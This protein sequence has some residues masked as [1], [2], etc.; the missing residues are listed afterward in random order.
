MQQHFNEVQKLFNFGEKPK[1]APQT[2]QPNSV[3]QIH[4]QSTNVEEQLAKLSDKVTPSV[5]TKHS[6]LCQKNCTMCAKERIAIIEQ[7]R[8]NPQLCVNS[9]NKIC[10]ACRHRPQFFRCAEQTSPITDESIDDERANPTNVSRC[11]ICLAL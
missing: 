9:N 4:P 10:D 5:Q 1:H 3:T 6:L 7:S 8:S 11:N 2:L